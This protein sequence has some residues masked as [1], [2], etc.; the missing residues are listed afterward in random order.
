M[1]KNM[2]LY[3]DFKLSQYLLH[4]GNKLYVA[5]NSRAR[6]FT[7]KCAKI[8]ACINILIDTI[9]STLRH[10]LLRCLILHVAINFRA[11]N[12]PKNVQKIWACIKISNWPNTYHIKVLI[13]YCL[14]LHVAINFRARKFTKKCANVRFF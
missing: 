11:R 7:K 2:S 10:L 9:P 1:C 5:I 12:S 13:L 8:W 4:V 6:K 14:I 3:Q